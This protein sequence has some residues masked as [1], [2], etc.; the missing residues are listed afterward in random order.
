MR[1][2]LLTTKIQN[3]ANATEFDVTTLEIVNL[4]LEQGPKEGLDYKTIRARL[5][6]HAEIDK[7]KG[8]ESEIFLDDK[9]FKTLKDAISPLKFHGRNK[10]V[11]ALVSEL[12]SD[13][14]EIEET[15]PLP[16][17]DLKAV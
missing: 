17:N 8:G 15:N 13:E 9:D 6:V 11:D 14:D 1:L 16:T 2:S 12:F 5:R 3:V 7:L 10:V 4:A